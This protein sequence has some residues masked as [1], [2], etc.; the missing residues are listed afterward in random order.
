MENLKLLAPSSKYS[1]NN[2]VRDFKYKQVIH[3]LNI[4]RGSRREA[5]ELLGTTARSIRYIENKGGINEEN[6]D[7]Q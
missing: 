2:S 7:I 1:L 4:C 3:A 6:K 5:A